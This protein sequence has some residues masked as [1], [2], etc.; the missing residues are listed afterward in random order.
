MS[1]V[2]AELL[3]T[4]VAE[5]VREA[6]AALP[7][8]ARGS[9]AVRHSND[10]AVATPGAGFVSRDLPR[11]RTLAVRLATDDDLAD[12]VRQ[13]LGLFEN[14]KTRS[15]LRNGWLRFSLNGVAGSGR[16][17]IGRVG[18]GILRIERGVLTERQVASAADSGQSIVV[19]PGA[20]ITPLARDKA[21]TLG[22]HIEK[23][24]R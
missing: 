9:E 2:P 7:S 22:V 11:R 3:R 4:L 8:G 5:A 17:V 6:V 14:P 16:N 18:G 23:E 15:D 10:A 12:F 1:Q 13:L 24:R 19:A 21:R 20:V